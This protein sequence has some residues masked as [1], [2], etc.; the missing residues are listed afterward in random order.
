MKKYC[1]ISPYIDSISNNS[2]YGSTIT[3]DDKFDNGI[4]VMAEVNYNEPP[5]TMDLSGFPMIKWYM[6]RII[7]AEQLPPS[8]ETRGMTLISDSSLME[9]PDDESAMLWFK[10]EYGR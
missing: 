2:V 5:M 9:F 10:L 8:I 7:N 6:Y 3:T 4:R 1:I